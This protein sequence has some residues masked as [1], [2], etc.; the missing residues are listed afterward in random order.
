MLPTQ[1]Y[2]KKNFR[3]WNVKTIES[4]AEIFYKSIAAKEVYIEVFM[5][6]LW[7]R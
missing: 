4:S 2:D 3:P 6:R 5:H 7:D 1:H